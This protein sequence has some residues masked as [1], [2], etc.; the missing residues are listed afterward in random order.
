ML[1]WTPNR[2]SYLDVESDIISSL[3]TNMDP[4]RLV[5]IC[6]DHQ[7]SFAY[8]IFLTLLSLLLKGPPTPVWRDVFLS[9]RAISSLFSSHFLLNT[10]IRQGIWY[11]EIS[12]TI[13][14]PQM[15]YNVA[16][17][18][19]CFVPS[20]SQANILRMRLLS[21]LCLSS[22]LR[23]SPLS[24]AWHRRCSVFTHPCLLDKWPMWGWEVFLS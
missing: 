8:R 5:T 6:I 3:M 15:A 16:F 11:L 4:C 22:L 19:L 10:S 9:T 14:N 18:P 24:T 13:T 17:L 21:S 2:R 20:T 12:K 1:N 23:K 7:N